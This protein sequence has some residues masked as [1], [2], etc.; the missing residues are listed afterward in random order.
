MDMSLRGKSALAV[1]PQ[2][3][4]RDA[5]DEVDFGI[6]ADVLSTTAFIFARYGAVQ[7]KFGRAVCRLD[8]DLQF[9]VKRQCEAQY[10]ESRPNIGR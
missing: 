8:R 9:E 1:T 10:V 4:K 6:E 5:G 7:W 2:D 3:I